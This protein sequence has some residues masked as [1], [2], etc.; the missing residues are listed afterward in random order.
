MDGDL[1]TSIAGPMSFHVEGL[2]C[3][4]QACA[5]P[6]RIGLLVGGA[7]RPSFSSPG[8]AA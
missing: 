7:K 2:D 8:N 4:E 3:Q 5:L 6:G 1:K